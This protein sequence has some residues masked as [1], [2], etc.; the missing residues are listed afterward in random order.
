MSKDKNKKKVLFICTH[1][2]A[3]LQ[4]AEGLIRSLCGDVYDAYSAGTFCC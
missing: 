3:R 2:S 4:M 1:N